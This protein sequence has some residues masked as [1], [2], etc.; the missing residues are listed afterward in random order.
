M[1]RPFHGKGMPR[2]LGSDR[3]G[4]MFERGIHTLSGR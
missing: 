3:G 2:V 4:T 1:E